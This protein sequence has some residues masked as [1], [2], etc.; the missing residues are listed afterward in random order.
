ML[1]WLNAQ[2]GKPL[3]GAFVFFGQRFTVSRTPPPRTALHESR[4]SAGSAGVPHPLG[5]LAT[6]AFLGAFRSGHTETGHSLNRHKCSHQN[7]YR[8][9]AA[10]P[11]RLRPHPCYVPFRL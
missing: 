2:N 8:P 6:A 10:Q 7:T 11:E 5:L 1:F 4:H 3:Y 9:Q